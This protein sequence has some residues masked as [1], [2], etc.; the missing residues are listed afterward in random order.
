MENS[1]RLCRPIV[2]ALASMVCGAG[3]A[4]DVV[5][6][7]WRGQ[8]KS[9]F[10]EWRFSADTN[11]A[12][13]DVASNAYGVAQAAIAT[14]E[15]SSGWLDR[16]PGLGTNSGYWDLGR[17]GT[18]TLTIPNR[19]GASTNSYKYI[20]V[21]V[22]QW[23]DG[24]IYKEYASVSISGATALGGQRQLVESL[25]L[26]GWWVDQTMWRLAPNPASETIL[27]GGA[28]NGSVVEQIVVD[29]RCV[30]PGCPPDLLVSADSGQ[31]SKT[32]VTWPLP[33]VDG[34]TV[35]NINCTPPSG[36]TFPLGT[37][38]VTCVFMDSAGSTASCAFNVVAMDGEPPVVTLNGPST[39]L[40]ECH[41]DFT[42]PGA[43]ATD[44][45]VGNLPVTLS[46]GVNPN[47]AGSYTLTYTATDPAGNAAS[48]IRTVNVVDTTPP[49]ISCSGNK[50]VECGQPWNF[51][52][53]TASDAC[54]TV[55]VIIDSTVTNSSGFC[56]ST[57][58]ATRTWKASDTSGN[59]AKCSQKVTV[60]DTTPPTI[61]CA[62]NKTV[63][64][65]QPWTFDEPT[66]NDTCSRVT[67]TIV[68]TVTNVS[69]G[70]SLV[71]TRTWKASDL[72]D[73]QA[74]CS[75][76]VTVLVCPPPP[77]I[78][79]ALFRDC[80]ADGVLTGEQGLASWTVKLKRS[81]DTVATT[82]SDATGAYCFSNLVAGS[83]TVAVTRPSG[84]LQTVDPD[85]TKD[86]KTIVTLTAGQSKTGVNF[87]Y[88][89]TAPAVTLAKIG[90]STA[91]RGDT[92]T[93]HFA[94]TNTGNTCFYRMTVDDPLLGGQ[95][96]YQP[97]VAPGQ[98]FAF[99]RTYV[100]KASDPNP[101]KN[102]ATATGFP[103]IGQNVTARASWSVTLL[104]GPSGL[105]A[106]PGN[107]QVT[108]S[109]NAVS[110]TIS[111]KVKRSTTNGGP[112]TTIK[113]GLTPTTYTD[114]TVTN[115]TP[116]YYVVS[117]V[118]VSGESPDSAQVY[119]IP[120]GGLPS[121]WKTRDIGSVAATG[122]ASYSGSTRMFTVVGSGADIGGAADEFRFVYQS[123]D[124]NCTIVAQ[125]VSVQNTD[126]GAKAGVMIRET[127]NA[128][129][130]DASAF[131]TP[132]NGVTFQNRTNS[133]GSSLSTSIPGLAAPYWLKVVRTGDT[134][135]AY[136]SLDGSSWTLTGAATISMGSSV[137]IG[138][139]V[140]SHNDGILC[141]A[142]FDKVT[143]TP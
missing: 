143:A 3:Y 113:I 117:A 6:P 54:G 23:Y 11:P 57:F 101:L 122:G 98:G 106:T 77:G 105:T 111:Y 131:V 120:T 27:I 2:I 102:T 85:S 71:A 60:L 21:Q 137:Y 126:P 61:S 90:P 19:P 132:G 70:N 67:V 47:I 89:G 36:S 24:G 45:C 13:P 55:N 29:T 141:G 123:G 14:G 34:C 95:L 43:T 138:L 8:E 10:Q 31:C 7:C 121:P 66:A 28:F 73:N 108:L 20:W 51:D 46:G 62:A 68:G 107:A 18:M 133:G 127:L 75:Q 134:F 116:Y 30:E 79:G 17:S 37:N 87:G 69:L 59:T 1:S 86:D 129:S 58:E 93:Y 118:A 42:D 78:C 48:A 130:K 100:V 142:T 65:A 64:C 5:V 52:D 140:T 82:R 84:Y 50:T 136:R 44:A 39:M 97:S 114:T 63:P 119:A 76:T 128:N 16:T 22:T 99:D 109:W 53:P 94:V 25:P 125:V 35:T 74:Q 33:L 115:G 83:Y 9:T 139:V 12:L 81:G 104:E 15:F 96:F 135:T 4:H 103:P 88:T 26:G 72:C 80:D 38:A 56:G 92:I 41:G 124:G 91:K 110:G 49:S 112:Y 32:N 40:V